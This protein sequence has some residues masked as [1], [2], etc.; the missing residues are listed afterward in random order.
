[1]DSENYEVPKG[2]IR[3]EQGN[4]RGWWVRVM[5]EGVHFRKLFSDN[6]YGSPELALEHA[7]VHL[8]E[9][10]DAFPRSRKAFSTTKRRGKGPIPGVWKQKTKSRGHEYWEWFAMWSP[11]P[12][13]H[14]TR[15]F[16]VNKYGDTGAMR[17]AIALRLEKLKEINDEFPDDE[18]NEIKTIPKEWINS[19][20][21]ELA[22]PD[23]KGN[24]VNLAPHQY[25]GEKNYSIHLLIERSKKLRGQKIEVFIQEHGRVFC[26]LCEVNLKEKYPWVAMDYIEVHHIVPLSELSGPTCN[27]LDDLV[28]VCPNCHTAIHQGDA[29][30]NYL[31]AQLHFGKEL[32]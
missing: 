3:F 5:R 32:L 31:E 20:L 21:L 16:S 13:V 30:D 17:K 2:I 1:M 26:Q 15:R 6:V 10:K 23:R 29:Q 25:E 9:I 22:V 19:G 8:K 7:K 27:S 28:L 24:A 12:G 4:T 18:T 11:E 14:K